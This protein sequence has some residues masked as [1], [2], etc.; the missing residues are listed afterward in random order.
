MKTDETADDEYNAHDQRDKHEVKSRFQSLK[1]LDL[2]ELLEPLFEIVPSLQR[3]KFKFLKIMFKL[4]KS[5][6]LFVFIFI[7]VQSRQKLP[8]VSSRH[9]KY[10]RTLVD[11]IL[12]EGLDRRDIIRLNS[13]SICSFHLDGAKNFMTKISFD[14]L[15]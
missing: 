5:Y 7:S 4:L 12:W 15:P 8:N 2:H 6:H 1:L 11:W 13:S 10:S 14:I 3:L 9:L